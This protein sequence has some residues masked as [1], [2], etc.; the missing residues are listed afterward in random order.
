MC[1]L[2]LPVLTQ[3]GQRRLQGPGFFPV[4]E[5]KPLSLI[6]HL[7]D[8]RPLP[9]GCPGFTHHTR[10]TYPSPSLGV[11]KRKRAWAGSQVDLEAASYQPRDLDGLP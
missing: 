9:F 3:L 6:Y 8:L 7:A 2:S 1:L 10:S 4:R 11:S 5:G